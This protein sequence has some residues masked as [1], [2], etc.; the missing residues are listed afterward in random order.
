MMKTGNKIYLLDTNVVIDLM[1]GQQNIADEISK[2]KQVFLPVFA[3]GE[4][5]LGAESS[6]RKQHHIDQIHSFLKIITVLNT[7]DKT[8]GVYGNIK[9]YLKSKGTPIP[10]ND[11]WIAALAIEH[12][13]PIVTKDSHFKKISDVKMV[14]W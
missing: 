4:L 5:Y 12:K 14:T 2:S 13:L 6:K 11:I 1:K 10:E 8:A 9:A 7:S 3:L